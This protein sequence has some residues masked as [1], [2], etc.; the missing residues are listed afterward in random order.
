MAIQASGRVIRDRE[1]LELIVERHLTAPASDVWEWLTSSAYLRKWIGSWTGRPHVGGTIAFTMAFEEASKGEPVT[2]LECE[3]EHRLAL[4]WRAGV[5]T[6]RIT[7]SIAEV[8]EVSRVYLSQR[9]S[10]A[11]EAGTIGP[12]W[13]YYLDRLIAARDGTAMPAFE[14]YYPV[15][16]PYYERLAMDGDPMGWPAT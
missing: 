12:R 10:E 8:D 3:P 5:D 6:W 4:Q 7:V 16:R 13:E 9:L 1:G 14:D 15:Q 2:I 11:R